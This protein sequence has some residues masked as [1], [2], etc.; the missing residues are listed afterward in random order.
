MKLRQEKRTVE[1]VLFEF[2]N[3]KDNMKGPK[4]YL[5]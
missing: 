3:N 5:Q 1:T 2:F 4:A